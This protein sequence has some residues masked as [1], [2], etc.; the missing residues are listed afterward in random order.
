MGFFYAFV[1]CVICALANL[2]GVMDGLTISIAGMAFC[3]ALALFC[4]VMFAVAM[5]CDQR[6]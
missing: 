1:L 5:I 3:A 2:P 4:L 6:R